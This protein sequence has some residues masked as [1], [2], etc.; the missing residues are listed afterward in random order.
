MVEDGLVAEER[1]QARFHLLPVAAEQFS[2]RLVSVVASGPLSA[3]FPTSTAGLWLAIS[4]AM[5]RLLLL[6][7]PAPYPPLLLVQVQWLVRPCV[8]ESGVLPRVQS[9]LLLC[10]TCFCLRA[11]LSSLA[12]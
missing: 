2:F 10:T 6:L 11:N 4:L 3:W 8:S 1:F 7:D 12:S 5:V 9:V